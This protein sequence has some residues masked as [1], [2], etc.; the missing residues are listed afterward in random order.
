MTLGRKYGMLFNMNLSSRWSRIN[1]TIWLMAAL[2]CIAFFVFEIQ[3]S[4]QALLSPPAELQTN[5]NRLG[6]SLLAYINYLAVLR[7]LYMLVHLFIAGFIIFKSPNETFAVFVAYFLLLM[8]TTFW[9]LT[10]EI[11]NQPEFWQTPRAL[12]NV[13]TS[14]SLLVFFL[15]FPDGRFNPRWTIPF[16]VIMTFF[17]VIEN[18]FP[19]SILSPK[20]WQW[21]YAVWLSLFTMAVMIYVPVTRYRSLT[22]PITRQ[23]TKWVIYGI[24]SSLILFF[25]IALPIS[26]GVSSEQ[27]TLYGLFFIT[28]STL[29]FMLIPLSIGIAVTQFR[30]WDIDPIINRTLVYGALSFLTILFTF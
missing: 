6:I 5:L 1:Q 24:A 15:I 29:A 26:L 17:L 25:L 8:G 2:I 9:T 7:A 18:F 16:A 14:L 12:A 20:N 22:N 28:G 4:R 19:Q 27:G 30:L 11:L 23:Q 21:V 3:L 10:P 13:F